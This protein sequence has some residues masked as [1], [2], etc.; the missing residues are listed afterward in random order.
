[1][2]IGILNFV[3]DSTVDPASLAKICEAL[4]FESLF[5]AEHPVVP[6]HYTRADG[7]Q[8]VPDGKPPEILCRISDLFVSL[9]FAAAVTSRI[10]LGTGIC[11]VPERSPLL[12]A[13]E[14]ATL[15]LYSGGRV[16]FG[17]GAGWNAEESAV[18]GVEFRRRW[19]MTREYIKAMKELW[20]KDE[21]AFDGKFV[22]FPPVYCYP[23]PIQ[24]PH[25]PVLIGA[26]GMQGGAFK[27]QRALKDTVT[28]GDGWAPIG[29]TPDQ[30][31]EG[32]AILKNLCGEAGRDFGNMDI[33]L[34]SP[35]GLKN[36]RHTIE[37]YRD[38]G[39][40][41]LVFFP[42]ALAPDKAQA[43]LESLAK[44]YVR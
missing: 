2:K 40:T 1:M 3:G 34:F 44:D 20:T 18:M 25:P 21:S 35:V 32:V 13:K 30:L 6:T 4:G 38:A 22:K 33:T 39:A 23:K 14:V 9:S 36:G 10:K 16:I 19:V 28:I 17:I 15:D 26:G 24:K 42:P 8:R 41:R 29:L 5:L 12:T 43:E 27:P 11:L 7:S 31:S 37:Q